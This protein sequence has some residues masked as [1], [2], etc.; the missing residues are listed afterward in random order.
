ME[1]LLYGIFA[2]TVCMVIVFVLA[3]MLYWWLMEK[4]EECV[5]ERNRKEMSRT[6][7]GI[8]KQFEREG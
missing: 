3:A 6:L 8:L 2:F 4:C 5:R 1:G 7:P